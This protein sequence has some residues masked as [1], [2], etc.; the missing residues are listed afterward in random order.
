MSEIELGSSSEFAE[1]GFI[2][3]LVVVLVGA[4]GSGKRGDFENEILTE[5]IEQHLTWLYCYDL[6]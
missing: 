2:L 6:H 1:V 4:I 5:S 3:D